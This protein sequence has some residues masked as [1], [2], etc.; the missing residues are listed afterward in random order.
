MDTDK[1]MDIRAYPCDPWLI[2]WEGSQGLTR[3]SSQSCETGL[4]FYV[5]NFALLR[6]A[7]HYSDTD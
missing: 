4:V 1:K 3:V 2:S 7:P 5:Q 6:S